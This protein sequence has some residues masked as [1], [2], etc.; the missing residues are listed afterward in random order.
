MAVK[1]PIQVNDVVDSFGIPIANEA[2]KQSLHI[3]LFAV[4]QSGSRPFSLLGNGARPWTVLPNGLLVGV[5]EEIFRQ[6]ENEKD[7]HITQTVTLQATELYCETARDLLASRNTWPPNG[8]KPRLT[9]NGYGLDTTQAPCPSLATLLGH[10]TYI[11]HNRTVGAT[12]VNVAAARGHVIFHVTT[13]KQTRNDDGKVVK[14]IESHFH[15]AELAPS[16]RSAV[17]KTSGQMLVE[18]NAINGSLAT[19]EKCIKSLAQG[20]KPV[21]RDSKLTLLLQPSMTDGA[22]MTS[23]P[24]VSDA[25]PQLC[26]YCVAAPNQKQAKPTTATKSGQSKSN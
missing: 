11:N 22:Q 4:G 24:V 14:E 17:A 2:L 15:F 6:M 21:L 9:N 3:S 26:L 12:A 19:L 7:P 25:E 8:H 13:T 23:V 10:L 1:A 18:G 16:E 20:R 5:C